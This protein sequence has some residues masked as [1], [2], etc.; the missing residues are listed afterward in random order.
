ME[1]FNSNFQNKYSYY[2]INFMKHICFFDISL[3]KKF[4]CKHIYTSKYSQH[5]FSN[6]L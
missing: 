4:I 6:I 5:F 3:M 2:N 1:F